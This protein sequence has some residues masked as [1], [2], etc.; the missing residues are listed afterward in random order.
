MVEIIYH[1]GGDF[2]VSN[3]YLEK[4]NYEN[5][6]ILGKYG[7]LRLE[8]LKNHKK[9]EYIILY[10]KNLFIHKFILF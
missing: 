3:L 8:Y 2:F 6:Y 9:A 4:G 5:N 10:Y 1:K 7:R